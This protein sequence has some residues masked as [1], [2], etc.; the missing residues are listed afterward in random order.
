MPNLWLYP[1]SKNPS[2]NPDDQRWFR[3]ADGKIEATLVN[4]AKLVEAGR[5]DEE[6]QWFAPKNAPHVQKGEEMFVYCTKGI[7]IVGKAII[8]DKGHLDDGR[9]YLTPNFDLAASRALLLAPIPDRVVLDRK[10]LV[11]SAVV[12]LAAIETELHRRFPV[13]IEA[14]DLSDAAI[15][16][17][18]SSGRAVFDDVAAGDA[19]GQAR[20]RKG[21]D[22]IRKLTRES[23][24]GAVCDVSDLNLL[25][26]SHICRW[27]DYPKR[28]GH[29]SNVICLCRMHDALFEAGYWGLDPDL[30]IVKSTTGDST[31]VRGLL[32]QMTSFRKPYGAAPRKEYVTEHRLRMNLGK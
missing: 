23:Y 11:R 4:F 15:A 19:V 30:R 6:T 16:E 9:W 14:F 18:V 29:L 25:I 20:R 24:G 22:V 32:D 13:C 27:S 17:A 28:R 2:G 31:F 3:L 10:I 8:V 26:A 21:Q 12:N 5:I 1:L 7:G